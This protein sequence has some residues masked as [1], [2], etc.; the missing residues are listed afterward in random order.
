MTTPIKHGALD[1]QLVSTAPDEIIDIKQPGGIDEAT[2]YIF[3]NSSV[4]VE[5]AETS[6]SV[7]TTVGTYSPVKGS[8]IVMRIPL[9]WPRFIRIAAAAEGA[10]VEIRV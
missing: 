8:P 10:S 6:N 2:V 9:D 1:R 4:T 3:G 5:G 7:F